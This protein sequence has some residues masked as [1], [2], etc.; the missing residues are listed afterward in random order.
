MA[1][2][3]QR[4]RDS[5]IQSISDYRTVN[6]SSKRTPKSGADARGDSKGGGTAKPAQAS[7]PQPIRVG[8]PSVNAQEPARLNSEPSSEPQTPSVDKTVVPERKTSEVDVISGNPDLSRIADSLDSSLANAMNKVQP[9]HSSPQ[10][11]VNQTPKPSTSAKAK[12]PTPQTHLTHR[13]LASI[14]SVRYRWENETRRETDELQR[15]LATIKELAKNKKFTKPGMELA[16]NT[17]AVLQ[18]VVQSSQTQYAILDNIQAAIAGMP[19]T[20]EQLP[21]QINVLTER[22]EL[23]ERICSKTIPNLEKFVKQVSDQMTQVTSELATLKQSRTDAK[24]QKTPEAPKGGNISHLTT[25]KRKSRKRTST[26]KGDHSSLSPQLGDCTLNDTAF[27]QPNPKV[28]KQF[29]INEHPVSKAAQLFAKNGTPPL[30][31]LLNYVQSVHTRADLIARKIYP[32]DVKYRELRDRL[33]TRVKQ[34][35]SLAQGALAKEPGTDYAQVISKIHDARQHHARE[36]LDICDTTDVTWNF[37]WEIRNEYVQKGGRL[38]D[39]KER[40]KK[41]KVT[42]EQLRM[43]VKAIAKQVRPIWFFVPVLNMD[44]LYP[45]P[46]PQRQAKPPTEAIVIDS[47]PD[48]TRHSDTK[49]HLEPPLSPKHDSDSSRRSSESNRTRTEDD[50]NAN[51]TKLIKN[52]PLVSKKEDKSLP[53]LLERCVTTLRRQGYERD[54]WILTAFA[55]RLHIETWV[56]RQLGKKI[57]EATLDEVRTHL[58]H[59]YKNRPNVAAAK[60]KAMKK[61][62]RQSY[63]DFFK[64]LKDAAIDAYPSYCTN[65]ITG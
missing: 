65:A 20:L 64:E 30:V 32:T 13:K 17:A 9:R 54:E 14:T 36:I 33:Y 60:F 46:K 28:D 39:Q 16:A 8:T 55:E 40:C 38:G 25:P 22:L 52:L 61:R 18:D 29:P 12:S 45:E 58:D 21:K 49:P 24:P 7:Q 41:F 6:M 4:L 23:T 62:H 42:K 34:L 59:N 35:K 50:F 63:H 57:T 56:E 26:N 44:L 15:R 27:L 11:D 1:R 48:S 3:T 37:Y 53:R 31:T 2:Q 43:T 19:E 47:S 10:G 5:N 51:L